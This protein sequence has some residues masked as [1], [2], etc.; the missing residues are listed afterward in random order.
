VTFVV[1]AALGLLG[2]AL[3]NLVV[4]ALAS[5]GVARVFGVRSGKLPFKHP[6]RDALSTVAFAA[7]VAV[8]PI[9]SY[10]CAVALF[11]GAIRSSGRVEHDGVV[12]VAAGGPADAAG[13]KSGDR[14]VAVDGRPIA[15]FGDIKPALADRAEAHVPVVV[16]RGGERITLDVVP[17]AAARIRVEARPHTAPVPIGEALAGAFAQP[18][19]V[20]QGGATGFSALLMPKHETLGG[21]VG[22]VATTAR[23]SRPESARL[24]ALLGAFNSYYWPMSFVIAYGT[25]PRRRPAALAPPAPA[26]RPDSAANG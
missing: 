9:A 12:E 5:F 15:T 13:M 23:T 24:L 18:F 17:D 22:I 6:P 25:R 3:L 14:V 2:L 10:L 21:P 19:R 20:L 1:I 4:M 26:P 7:V 16:E 8:G 11:F